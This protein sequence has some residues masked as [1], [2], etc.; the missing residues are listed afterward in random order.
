MPWRAIYPSCD[1]GAARTP[2]QSRRLTPT[3]KKIAFSTTQTVV[4]QRSATRSNL[5]LNG[6]DNVIVE[7][8]AVSAR[9]GF[10]GLYHYKASNRGRHSILANYG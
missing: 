6:I 2:D 4:V 8:S 3:A 5:S 1:E 9:C 10:V 7:S